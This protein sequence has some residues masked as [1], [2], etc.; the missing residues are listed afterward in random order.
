MKV[1]LDYTQEE[2]DRQYEH[3]NIVPDAEK[4]V[5][6]HQAES[7]RVRAAAQGR[8]DIA[9]GS[10]ED[11]LLDIYLA[12]GQGLAPIMV[13]FH[14]GRW[15]MGSKAS[16]CEA[17][18][19]YTAQGVHFVSVNF[20]LLPSVTMDTLIGQCRDAIVWLWRNAGTFG[21]DRDRMFVHGK[22]SGAHVAAMMVITDWQAQYDLPT[23]LIKGGLLVSGMYDLEPVRLTFRNEWLK[24]DESGAARNSPIRHI[25]ERGCP[26]IVGVGALESEEFRRQPREFVDAWRAKGLD[27]QFIVLEGRH[28]FTVNV[29][30]N[31]AQSA[32]VAPF[33]GWMG[34]TAI[35]AE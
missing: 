31:A 10:G 32:L 17:A 18:E 35:A 27:C 24:L 5:A 25:P 11:E 16:N 12:D 23:D 34:L 30:M 15:A 9:Y 1:Y 20:S 26:L 29:D 4:Y 7:E 21:G 2:L 19:V 28:H 8:F 6:A 13:F 22:S 3:R 33:L 14:G